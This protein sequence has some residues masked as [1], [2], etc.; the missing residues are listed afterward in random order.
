[1][2]S[3]EEATQKMFDY[4]NRNISDFDGVMIKEGSDF[5][6]YKNGIEHIFNCLEALFTNPSLSILFIK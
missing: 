5:H 4:I 3:T 2:M 1:M 6:I